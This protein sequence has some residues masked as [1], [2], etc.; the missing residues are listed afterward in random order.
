[1]SLL[2]VRWCCGSEGAPAIWVWSCCS[3]VAGWATDVW[4]RCTFVKLSILYVVPVRPLVG[5]PSSKKRSNV[6]GKRDSLVW[7]KKEA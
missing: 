6:E 3:G 2:G 1:M 4:Y 5:V 7:E